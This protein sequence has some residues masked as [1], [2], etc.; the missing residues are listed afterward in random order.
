MKRNFRQLSRD[1]KTILEVFYESKGK[2][3]VFTF[4]AQRTGANGDFLRLCS[5]HHG[6][7]IHWH[8]G[9]DESE[10][11]SP[12]DLGYGALLRLFKREFKIRFG[13]HAWNLLEM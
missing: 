10:E 9:I 1:G 8:K 5:A 6:K 13:G 11:T 12:K 7:R 3:V 2:A 4:H